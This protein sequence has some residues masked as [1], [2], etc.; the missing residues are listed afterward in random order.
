MCL[1]SFSCIE[2]QIKQVMLAPTLIRWILPNKAYCSGSLYHSLL[3]C[4]VPNKTYC[5]GCLFM[6]PFE[7][8]GI[9][10]C[11]LRPLNILW[12]LCF[13]AARRGL[14]CFWGHE[15]KILIFIWVSSAQF[16]RTVYLIIIIDWLFCKDVNKSS[17]AGYHFYIILNLHK[18]H[19]VITFYSIC[20]RSIIWRF[21]FWLRRLCV[22]LHNLLADTRLT[23]RAHLRFK[24]HTSTIYMYF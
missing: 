14:Y 6:S 15:V 9:L 12:P 3:F 13:K 17:R 21:L 24:L 16:L 19:I 11:E 2:C 23:G 5:A 8:S 10:L 1:L 7:K 18:K 4:G 22:F 20:R